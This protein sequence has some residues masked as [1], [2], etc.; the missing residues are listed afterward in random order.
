M[1]RPTRRLLKA[2]R[3]NRLTISQ[4]AKEIRPV[5]TRAHVGNVIYMREGSVMVRVA[6]CK[7][8]GLKPEEVFGKD[9]HMPL[10]RQVRA[11]D[12]GDQNAKEDAQ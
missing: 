6:I 1:R 2:L 7:R 3:H 8:L 4:L 12:K 10:K 9:W 11:D 5:K